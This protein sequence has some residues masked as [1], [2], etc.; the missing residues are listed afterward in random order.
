[1]GRKSIAEIRRAEIIEAFFNVVAEKGFLNATMR[2]IAVA[3][4]CSQGMLHHYFDNKETMVLA[5]TEYLVMTYSAELS[6]KIGLYDSATNRLLFLFSWL[7][8]PDRFDLRFSWAWME[9][10]T[11]S[12]THPAISNAMTKCYRNMKDLVAG[13]IRNGIGSGEFRNVDPDLMANMILG[14]L[15]GGTVLF[16]VDKEAPPIET[17]SKQRADLFLYYLKRS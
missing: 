7:R 5:A 17:T 4:G 13:I 16:V 1:M 14:S 3:A 8:D 6:D 10:W 15:E 9:F 12:K 11:L 2:E